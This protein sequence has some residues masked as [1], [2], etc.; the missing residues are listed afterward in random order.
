MHRLQHKFGVRSCCG[1][2]SECSARRA[3]KTAGSASVYVSEATRE[4]D[5]EGEIDVAAMELIGSGSF[6]KVNH[7]LNP[8]ANPHFTT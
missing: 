4:I 6:G 5:V 2:G 8:P 7:S 3:G 1:I